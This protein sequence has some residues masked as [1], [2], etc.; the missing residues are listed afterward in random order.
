[1][2]HG[3]RAQLG[4]SADFQPPEHVHC[5]TSSLPDDV[6]IV[7]RLATT[8]MSLGYC[9]ALWGPRRAFVLDVYPREYPG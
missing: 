9:K 5:L 3:L 8:H 6:D 2:E 4:A 7:T 1:M